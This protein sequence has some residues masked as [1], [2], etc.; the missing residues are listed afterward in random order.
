MADLKYKKDLIRKMVKNAN[1]N[2]TNNNRFN[3]SF[4]AEIA[5]KVYMKNF[6]NSN[7]FK[8][9]YT[10]AIHNLDGNNYT[11]GKMAYNNILHSMVQASHRAM[12][13]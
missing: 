4:N 11:K 9:H 3:A 13:M 10:K 8:A 6:V 5:E 2:V 12:G 1:M 7:K